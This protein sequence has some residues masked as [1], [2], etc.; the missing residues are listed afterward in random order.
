[1]CIRLSPPV[2]FR[3]SRTDTLVVKNLFNTKKKKK[4]QSKPTP[5]TIIHD[6]Q[7]QT[8]DSNIEEV[9]Y[10]NS[11]TQTEIRCSWDD[12]VVDKSDRVRSYSDD[13]AAMESV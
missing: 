13:N 4:K 1:M 10:V 5:S 9:Q 7:I 2:A 3:S 11:A 8:D 12:K 6:V